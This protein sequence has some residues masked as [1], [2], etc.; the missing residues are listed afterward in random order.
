MVETTKI[1]ANYLDQSLWLANQT[2][3]VVAVRSYLL[4]SSLASNGFVVPFTSLSSEHIVQ[5]KCWS[6]NQPF[7]WVEPT[8]FNF[9]SSKFNF[10]G[11]H[12]E[13]HSWSCWNLWSLGFYLGKGR[14]GIRGLI[15]DEA[16]L[17][18]PSTN[19]GSLRPTLH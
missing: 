5:T 1:A 16:L 3:G 8:C 2:Q 12:A 11:S 10:Q 14:G 19:L 15:L 4:H 13:Q 9:H 18:A 7:C 6:Q 17:G